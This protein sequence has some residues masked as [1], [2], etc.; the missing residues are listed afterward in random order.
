MNVL[1]LLRKGRQHHIEEQLR[2]EDIHVAFLQ[3]TRCEGPSQMATNHFHIARGGR[4]H[5]AAGIPYLGCEIWVAK[6]MHDEGRDN[7]VAAHEITI[8]DATPRWLIATLRCGAMNIMMASIHA[9]LA[10]NGEAVVHK[11]WD[12]FHNM[13]RKCNTKRLPIILGGDFNEELTRMEGVTGDMARDSQTPSK[14]QQVLQQLGLAIPLTHSQCNAQGS[15]LFTCYTNSG[16]RSIIDYIACPAMW[17]GGTTA[18]VAE[19]VDIALKTLDHIP[20]KTEIRAKPPKRS[21]VRQRN[22][23]PYDL[24]AACS[25]EG[26]VLVQNIVATIPKVPWAVHQ[27]SHLHILNSYVLSK[28]KKAFPRRS[29]RDAPSWMNAS[30]QSLLLDKRDAVARLIMLKRTRSQD[31]V[32]LTVQKQLV[33]DMANNATKAIQNDK[34]EEINKIA[35][36]IQEAFNN[37]EVRIAYS[38]LKRLFVKKTKITILTKDKDGKMAEDQQHADEIW[39][40]RWCD[41]LDG[42]RAT[43]Q[44]L[45]EEAEKRYTADT[46]Y[47][48]MQTI[49]ELDALARSFATARSGKKNG[50]DLLPAEIW[51]MAPADSARAFLPLITKT[52]LTSEWPCQWRGDIHV[53]IPKPGGYRGV[54]LADCSAKA[55]HRVLRGLLIRDVALK[56]PEL[57]FGGLPGRGTDF[58]GHTLMQIHSMLCRMGKPH[59]FLFVDVVKAFDSITR[60]AMAE[61]AAG[62][63]VSAATAAMHRRSWTVTPYSRQPAVL[64]KGVKQGDPV[65]DAAFLSVFVDLINVARHRLTEIGVVMQIPKGDGKDDECQQELHEIVEISYIDDVV[66]TIIE[67]DSACLLPTIARAAMIIDNV[68]QE[69][70][71]KCNYDS[72]KTSVVLHPRGRNA[73][74][75][76]QQ[77]RNDGYK[78]DIG[79]KVLHVVDEYTHLGMLHSSTSMEYK[80]TSAFVRRVFFRMKEMRPLFK[81]SLD[82]SSKDKAVNII[83]ASATYG[84]HTWNPVSA[85]SWKRL[86]TA[87]YKLLRAADDKCYN[88]A[89][90][91][92]K[93]TNME[94]I[95]TS[96]R[97][98]L[99]TV[100]RMKR[101][102][103]M[104]RLINQAPA[105]LWD[106]IRQN[107]DAEGSWLEMAKEDCYWALTRTNKLEELGD[108]RQDL[109]KW[110][111]LWEAHPK[112][113]AEIMKQIEKE[114]SENL[115]EAT[116]ILQADTEAVPEN[117][118]DA[119]CRCRVCG[120]FCRNKRVLQMHTTMAHRRRA[121]TGIFS[122]TNKC[123]FCNK[124][125]KDA[126][127]LQA[128]LRYGFKRYASGSCLGQA[129]IMRLEP[130]F[131]DQKYQSRGV[132]RAPD[133]APGD[134]VQGPLPRTAFTDV[135]VDYMDAD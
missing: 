50:C 58:A 29:G 121:S 65:S 120:K 25:P 2:K 113:W 108:P 132:T 33:R 61:A 89:A 112:Q 115:T 66:I 52:I 76:W 68:F 35:G 93:Y 18:M 12:D 110:I 42:Q 79:D 109:Q 102:R 26:K 69:Y 56:A 94:V 24:T 122:K 5:N 31:D 90:P 9:P 133:E 82:S 103:Y 6:V 134:K 40:D 36:M 8:M 99:K 20:V 70:S 128:H 130:Q 47:D 88:P 117:P 14:A 15:L 53:P 91:D 104:P 107:G 129:I 3:E 37:N 124:V 10:T 106:L 75:T 63:P 41:L 114:A 28:L 83:M 100:V 19:H 51:K 48:L 16:G 64:H 32:E 135:E 87:Y 96:G 95:L 125:Y 131:S 118:A 30:T 101:L 77:V 111:R 13:V 81:S 38:K 80:R 39:M 78:I 126:H 7:H 4:G 71:L 67:E 84:I 73:A 1:T 105:I 44:Q 45:F 72:G 85:C 17:I 57:T 59:A 55:L 119:P 116:E 123:V 92:E 34:K 11:Y 21:I 97:L 62:T 43:F 27:D 86:E 98:P 127:L 54:A 74:R 22:R 23:L 49:P 60:P 46:D